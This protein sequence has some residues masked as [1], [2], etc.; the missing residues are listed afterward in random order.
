[1]EDL[2]DVCVDKTDKVGRLCFMRSG[3]A[4]LSLAETLPL[5]LGRDSVRYYSCRTKGIPHSFWPFCRGELRHGEDSDSDQALA[6][7]ASQCSLLQNEFR[8]LGVLLCS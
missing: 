7:K 6:A 8:N 2:E 3:L 1:M 5:V 4:L